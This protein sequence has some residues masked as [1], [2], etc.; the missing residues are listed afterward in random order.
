M[1]TH[2]SCD[3]ENVMALLHEYHSA[4]LSLLKGPA[5]ADMKT[6]LVERGYF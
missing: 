6:S 4:R 1:V 3:P 5:F 2:F